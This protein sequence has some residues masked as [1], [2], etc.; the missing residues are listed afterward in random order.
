[1]I[2]ML[3]NST[4]SEVNQLDGLQRVFVVTVSLEKYMRKTDKTVTCIFLSQ[5]PLEPKQ[6]DIRN[7]RPIQTRLDTGTQPR[8]SWDHL[9]NP[10]NDLMGLYRDIPI[11][12]RSF[13][14]RIRSSV[15]MREAASDA[16]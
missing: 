16:E 9:R 13:T 2:A 8:Q 12:S 11:R 3:L 1:M 5:P 4:P 6:K 7:H 14:S 15:G 10:P